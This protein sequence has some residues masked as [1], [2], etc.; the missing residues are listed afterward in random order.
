MSRFKFAAMLA[1]ALSAAACGNDTGPSPDLVSVNDTF[2]G[3][4]PATA[5]RASC[6]TSRRQDTGCHPTSVA[7]SAVPVGLSLGSETS[8]PPAPSS[9]P[10]TQC[11]ARQ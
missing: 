9:W 7:D 6:S 11:R 1:I 3:T 5:R 10:T 4:L 2:N 8:P